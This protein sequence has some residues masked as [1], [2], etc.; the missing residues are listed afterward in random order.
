MFFEKRLERACI[1]DD[2][3]IPP[4]TEILTSLDL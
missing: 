4:E 3:K 2:R 1:N